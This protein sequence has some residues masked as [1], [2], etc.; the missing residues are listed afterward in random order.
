MP[1]VPLSVWGP[2]SPAPPKH[3]LH[4]RHFL[5]PTPEIPTSTRRGG[6]QGRVSERLSHFLKVTQLERAGGRTQL[7][8]ALASQP[9]HSP[10][11][12]PPSDMSRVAAHLL[13]AL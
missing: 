5:A 8:V 11:S 12:P 6:L 10:R 9:L 13:C 1:A 3:Q 7:H 2:N 4:A